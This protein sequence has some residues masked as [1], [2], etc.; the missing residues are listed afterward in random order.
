MGLL[1]EGGG[2][3]RTRSD[4]R[5]FVY[6]VKRL[7][8]YKVAEDVPLRQKTFTANLKGHKRGLRAGLILKALTT[9]LNS[10]LD[11]DLY[12]AR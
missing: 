12:T 7:L 4:R 10:T 5:A 8:F 6:P 2:R 3:G 1:F 11:S 9:P